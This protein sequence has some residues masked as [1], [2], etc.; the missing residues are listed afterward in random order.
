ML[1]ISILRDSNICKPALCLFYRPRLLR[2]LQPRR[3]AASGRDQGLPCS[4][5]FDLRRQQGIHI[6]NRCLLLQQQR[7]RARPLTLLVHR[8]THTR[9]RSVRSHLAHLCGRG[10]RVLR[11]AGDAVDGGQRQRVAAPGLDPPAS[12]P[13]VHGCTRVGPRHLV[14]GARRT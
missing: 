13:R 3:P 10:R 8:P 11:A 9:S 5:R 14:A 12:R 1:W 4:P 7:S 2:R 6:S